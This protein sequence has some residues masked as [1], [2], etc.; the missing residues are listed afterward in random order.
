VEDAVRSFEQSLRLQP[1]NPEFLQRITE[2]LAQNGRWS[3]TLPYLN[4]LIA[5]FP[6]DPNIRA[7]RDRAVNHSK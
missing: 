4:E 2:L 7:F 6:D 1:H 5:L 3:E